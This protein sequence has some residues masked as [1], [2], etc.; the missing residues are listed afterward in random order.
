MSN[1][2]KIP[3][4]GFRI[5]FKFILKSL[6]MIV[7]PEKKVKSEEYVKIGFNSGT[8]ALYFLFCNL[9]E[10]Y[11]KKNQVIVPAYTCY[12]VPAALKKAGFDIVICDIDKNTLDFNE[13]H[14]S[15]LINEN[16]L[17]VMATHL[18]ALPVDLKKIKSIIG[19]NDVFIIED[20]A[21]GGLDSTS[22]EISRFVILS[23]GRGKPQSTMGGGY[24][25]FKI[26]DK[27]AIHLLDDYRKIQDSTILDSVK[28]LVSLMLVNILLNP[29]LYNLIF[30]ISFL[31]LGKTIYPN[32][33]EVKKNQKL[34]EYMFDVIQY[35]D[36]F[37]HR[38]KI[39]LHY[40][41]KFKLRKN[42]FN[43]ALFNSSHYEPVRYPI[44]I[45]DNKE[46]R[47]NL[48]A[49]GVAE[50]YPSLISDLSELQSV[51]VNK[52]DDFSGARFVRKYLVTLPTHKLL[53]NKNLEDIVRFAQTCEVK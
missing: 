39:A 13:S 51:F 25:M 17:C 31:N 16:T 8:A 34:Q 45:D 1:I 6:Y 10:L 32:T 5:K 27:S 38:N 28:T 35:G 14:L 24:L 7:F 40:L 11:P 29:Y 12:S 44:Y 42:V 37:K 22:D 9:R 23:T 4:V 30:R 48:E 18:F 41:D 19:D 33:I 43:S 46:L 2:K 52:G 20:A 26:K 15:K 3:P 53:S 21:Q 47:K 36:I 50:M 49:Y